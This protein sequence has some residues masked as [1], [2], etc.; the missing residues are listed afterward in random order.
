[1]ISLSMMRAPTMQAARLRMRGFSSMPMRVAHENQKW[2]LK[3]WA[4]L[5]AGAAGLA[6]CASE[7]SRADGASTL[8][9]SL[10]GSK[11][12]MSTFMGRTMAFYEVI[13][14]KHL[15]VGQAEIDKAKALLEDYK[16]NGKKA[17]AGVTDE[18]LWEAKTCVEIN[19]HPV[20]GEALFAPGRMAAFVPANVP[21][22]IFMTM[23]SGAPMIAL[24]QVTNQTYNVVCNYVNRSGVDVDF[25]S[26]GKS[27]LLAVSSAITIAVT[28]NKLVS[29]IPALQS[30]GILVP[31]SAVAMAGTAN[32][33]FTRMDEWNGR[34]TPVKDADGKEVG[35]SLEAGKT[36]VLQTC[37]S[38]CILLP[39][40]PMVLPGLV[41]KAVGIT[42][43]GPRLAAELALVITA[44][45]GVMPACLAV[46][47][48]TMEIDVKD[49]EPE[50][51]N[52][53][54]SKGQKITTVYAN[55][56][57]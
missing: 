28:G 3:K 1:M 51:H 50:F 26:L 53:T 39:I 54:D 4:S 45:V 23:A 18:Q 36:A 52:L 8:P 6:L 15:L 46:L 35:M 32:L 30:L 57:L 14:P 25:M 55:K 43:F 2:N 33:G 5:G 47:P 27:Y 20:T 22:V 13:D 16:K 7:P 48:P 10:E 11:Y 37:L 44:Y 12:D 42:A 38:R 29:A 19:C 49:L 34:G 9:F 21:I 17:P 56:G 31:Y 41:C 40:V 24:S